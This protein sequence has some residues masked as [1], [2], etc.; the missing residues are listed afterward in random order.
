MSLPLTRYEQ[1]IA[2]ELAGIITSEDQAALDKAKAD[3]PEVYELWKEQQSLFAQEDVRS[4]LEQ[5][6]PPPV[7]DAPPVVVRR[8]QV[9]RVLMVTTSIAAI[10][11]LIIGSIYFLGHKEE[12]VLTVNTRKP[13]IELKLENGSVI[14]LSQEGKVQAGNISLSNQQKSLTY[15]AGNNKEMATLSVPAGKDYKVTLSDGTEIFMN[16]ATSLRFPISFNNASTREVTITGEAYIKVTKD[17]SHPF[18]VNTPEGSVQ[19][20]GTEFN[21]NS[22]EK[23]DFHVALVEGK[24]QFKAGRDSAILKPGFS[25]VYKNNNIQTE[26]FDAD[27]VLSW[28]KG[29]FLF[30]DKALEEVFKVIPRWFGQEVVIDNPTVGKEHFTGLFD[31]NKTIQQNLDVLKAYNGI[32]YSIDGNNVIHIK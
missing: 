12:S 17:P 22:Y 8:G 23:G 7:I 27:D 31:R 2:E 19:V 9:R 25:A 32:D 1:L 3:H 26:R 24:V 30:N 10:T 4:W 16:S 14:D 21:I 11:V 15:S 29:I 28:R 5:D 6:T 18:I 20:L 13:A